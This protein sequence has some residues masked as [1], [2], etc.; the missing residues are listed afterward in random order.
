MSMGGRGVYEGARVCVAAESARE[1]KRYIMSTQNTF[2][3]R[4]SVHSRWERVRDDRWA[5]EMVGAT[6]AGV[7][8]GTST[9]PCKARTI[10]RWHMLETHKSSM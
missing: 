2:R 9:K 6:L 7:T 3:A 8:A 1:H 10:R 4:I 5:A